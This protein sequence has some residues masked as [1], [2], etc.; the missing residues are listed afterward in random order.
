[1]SLR[2]IGLV[3]VMI[4]ATSLTAIHHGM[5]DTVLPFGAGG[6]LGSATGEAASHAFS[7]VGSTLILVAVFL[8]G[9][10]IFADISW[11]ELIDRL[12]AFA[13]SA[14]EFCRRQVVDYLD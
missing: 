2:A 14:F 8:F 5:H 3:L 7:H 10:T 9:L 11:L 13:L 12:G 1:F 4:S 6:I